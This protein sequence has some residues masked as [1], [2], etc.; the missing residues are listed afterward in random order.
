MISNQPNFSKLRIPKTIFPI[1]TKLTFP[2][3]TTHN[4]MVKSQK[5]QHHSI[6]RIIIPFYPHALLKFIFNM[7]KIKGFYNR[8]QI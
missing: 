6:K 4:G 5:S 8:E 2:T 3:I 7:H 1:T